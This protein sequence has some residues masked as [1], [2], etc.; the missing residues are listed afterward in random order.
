MTSAQNTRFGVGRAGH[1]CDQAIE[2][3]GGSRSLPVATS[4]NHSGWVPRVEG[5]LTADGGQAAL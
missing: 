1:R 4:G 3:N 5:G 2:Q